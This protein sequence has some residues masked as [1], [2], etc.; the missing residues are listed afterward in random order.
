MADEKKGKK[1]PKSGNKEE[2]KTKK[3][4]KKSKEAEVQAE[5]KLPSR[6]FDFYKKEVVPGLSKKFGYKNVFQVPKLEKISINVGVGLATQDPK[7]VDVVVKD[8]ENIAGQKPVITIAKKSVSNFKLR[9]GMK[10][11]CKVTLRRG[12]MYEFLDRLI[13]VAIPRIRDFRGVP[14]K[15]FDGNG[16]Y[17]LGVKEH[18]IFPEVNIDNV[19]KH[20]GMDITFVTS[21]ESDDEARE[22]LRAFGMPFVKREASVN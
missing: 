8:L 13:N 19:S 12:R 6:L 20:F 7:L 5:E 22:L 14:D 18:V 9:E 3:A 10:I 21:A 11:G 15:S 4:P 16:N 2:P 1:A 17:T